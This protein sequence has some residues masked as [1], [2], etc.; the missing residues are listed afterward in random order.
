MVRAIILLAGQGTR[1]NTEM[2]KQFL[3]LGAKPVFL[4]S[5]Q[6]FNECPKVDFITLVA[7][8][9][10][11]DYV[12]GYIN[13]YS[14]H[15]VTD[16]IEGGFERRSSVYNGLHSFKADYDDIVLIHD[17]ARPFITNEI[18]ERNIE[19]CELHDAVVTA[20]KNADSLFIGSDKVDHY[21]P[22]EGIYQV[23]TPQTFRY[24][25][26]KEA[27]K[28]NKISTDDAS[29]VLELDQEVYI[30]EGSRKNFKITT[31]D[32]F[33]MAKLLVK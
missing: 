8:K 31:Q 16:V 26:I 18:I 7:S 24:G 14:L 9:E 20:I 3:E 27:Y 21:V 6:T 28:N 15:K 17:A 1:M 19:E 33:E 4:H 32:D 29:L 22:R 11:I 25:I 2:P 5:L 13:I 23:Q 30:V 12:K 10:Y